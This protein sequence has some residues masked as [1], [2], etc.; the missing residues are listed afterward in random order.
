MP[1]TFIIPTT[2]IDGYF[3][4]VVASETSESSIGNSSKQIS[5]E[6]IKSEVIKNL[7]ELLQ[8]TFIKHK[9]ENSTV[10]LANSMEVR[11]DFRSVF[12]LKDLQAYCVAALHHPTNP[13]NNSSVVKL[14]D[15]DILYPGNYRIFWTLVRLGIRLK[16][17]PEASNDARNDI[18][19][20]IA[21]VNWDKP[22]NSL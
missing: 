7:E 1:S 4:K 5:I 10:C 16:Q 14:A 11:D 12:D 2:F 20:K 21:A 9:S 15:L 18:M 13:T 3:P 17:L 6:G 8:L 19:N 22:H